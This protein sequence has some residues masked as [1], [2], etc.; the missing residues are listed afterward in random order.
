MPTGIPRMCDG[1][2]I[3]EGGS[4]HKLRSRDDGEFRE[5][6]EMQSL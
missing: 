5:M 2:R 4:Y 3:I 1:R 6:V